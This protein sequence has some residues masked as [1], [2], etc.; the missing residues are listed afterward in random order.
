VADISN[1]DSDG[2][3]L[4]PSTPRRRLDG[5]ANRLWHTDASF[6]AVPGALSLLYA[7]VV[8]E[9]GGDTE[10]AD[11][12]AAYDALPEAKKKWAGRADRRTIR[13]GDSRGQLDV[14]RDKYTAEELR[15]AAAG[16]AAAGAHPS[17]LAPQDALS[18]GARLAH[19]RHAGGRRPPA[20]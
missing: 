7:H 1:L 3:V 19:R 17:R 10:F 4:Q 6:R 18:R 11:M 9:E 5:L 13:S 15:L 20:A 14:N 16:A 8:P 12:R 2:K